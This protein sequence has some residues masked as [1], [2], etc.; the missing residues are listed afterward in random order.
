MYIGNNKIAL[1][2]QQMI[3]DAFMQQ[4]EEKPFNKISISKLCNKAMVSR[5][6]FYSLF[7]SKENILYYE[8]KKRYLNLSH[9]FLDEDIITIPKLVHAFIQYIDHY[10]DFFS[11]LINNNLTEILSNG[12]KES[13]MSCDKLPISCND[14][15]NDYA[16]AF[17]SGALVEIISTYIKKGKMD[18][19]YMVENLLVSLFEGRYLCTK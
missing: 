11:I 14:L 15:K 9:F 4:L 6:T 16:I 7:D 17:I 3:S 12:I 19:L 18:D 2:S 1:Q 8:Y 13:L 5:Q 10:S